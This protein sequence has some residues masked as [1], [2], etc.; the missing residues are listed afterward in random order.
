MSDVSTQEFWQSLYEK[1]RTGWDLGG[2]TPVFRRVL[3][4][5]QLPPGR[6]IVLGAGRGY[7]ARLFA[8]HAFQVTAVDFAPAAIREL[9][10][11]NDGRAPLAIVKSD[12][13][14]L[15]PILHGVF[16][17]VLEYTFYC[18]IEPSRRDAY[19]TIVQQLLKPQG[20]FVGLIFPLGSRENG[21][22]YSVD[23]DELAEMLQRRGFQLEHR[24]IP[25][26]SVPG[27][28]GREE[29]LIMRKR[30]AAALDAGVAG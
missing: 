25:T 24:E 13:F 17:Y 8:R 21:P 15:N 7:D 26:D 29:L 10:A 4:E 1:G 20:R 14:D 30:D 3:E 28:F 12:I 23:T 18:A 16:D 22:P 9:H 11:R 27:R 2:P 5:R 6:M 19:A